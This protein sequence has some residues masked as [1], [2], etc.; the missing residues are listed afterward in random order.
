MK[1][2][3]LVDGAL[4]FR[5]APPVFELECDVLC[6]GAGSAGIYAADSAARNGAKVILLENDVSV[7]GMHILGNVRGCYYGGRGGSFEEDIPPGDDPHLYFKTEK[8]RLAMLDRLEN[9]GVRLLCGCTPTGV[10][11]EEKRVLGLLVFDGQREFGIRA[12]FTVDATSDGFLVRMLPVKKQ[13]GRPRD[14]KMAPYSVITTLC[15]GDAQQTVN[16]D[17]GYIDP[18]DSWDF[19]RKAMQAHAKAADLLAKGQLLNL[20]THTGVREGL[21]FAGEETLWYGDALLGRR[22]ERI[23]FWAYSDLDL[24]GHLRAL[25]EDLFQTWWVVCNMATVALRIPVPMG[26]VIPRGWKG[27]ATAGRCLSADSYAQAAVR[28]NRD[29]FRMGQCVGTAAAMAADGD[30]MAVDYSAYLSKVKDCFGADGNKTMG[31]DSPHRDIPYRPVEPDWEKNLPLVHTDTPG[32]LFWSAFCCGEKEKMADVLLTLLSD[33]Q[34]TLCRYNIGIA[35]GVLGDRRGLPILR[36]IADGRDCFFFKDCRRSNQFRSVAAVCLLGRL[37]DASDAK[38]LRQIVFSREEYA[39]ELYHTLQ[40]DKLYYGG[41][42]RSFLYFDMFTHAAAALV[43]LHRRHRLPM[44]DIHDAFADLLKSGEAV[45]R[46]VRG[47]S[48]AQFARE[49]VTSFLEQMLR[50][51]GKEA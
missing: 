3:Q 40:P 34:D 15:E 4:T 43:K 51:T 45:R 16:R 33:G 12:C 30:L 24:H 49:E 32:P 18:Y 36:E 27:I 31:Y 41:R 1:L 23:L 28:M 5:D 14:G 47:G 38:R 7:G 21:R 10:L 6:V 35:L 13:Y 26:A 50:D 8:K 17:A 11:V 46:I 44:E 42:D 37:G 29:C 48:G 9:A 19:S 22:P 39:R 20:A 2:L 25:D